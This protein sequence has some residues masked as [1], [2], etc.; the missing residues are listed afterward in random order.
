MDL[1]TQNRGRLHSQED[2]QLTNPLLD[3]SIASLCW[4]GWGFHQQA[5]NSQ[6]QLILM[7][8]RPNT[9]KDQPQLTSPLSY[10]WS[11]N[12]M[13]SLVFF[14]LL[15]FFFEWSSCCWYFMPQFTS[16][17]RADPDINP[18]LVSSCFCKRVTYYVKWFFSPF[19]SVPCSGQGVL[20]TLSK[21]RIKV[22]EFPG[23]RSLWQL[24]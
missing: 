20:G 22:N 14:N 15:F 21:W 19:C 11:I 16:V 1:F 8:S 2:K 6:P 13:L 3:D 23:N 5:L 4:Y 17:F 10:Q 7:L 12:S 18:E 9:E 24:W